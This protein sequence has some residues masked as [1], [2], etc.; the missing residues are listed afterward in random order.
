[1]TTEQQTDWREVVTERRGRD[2]YLRAVWSAY[3]REVDMIRM[4]PCATV[5]IDR[6]DNVIR[7]GKQTWLMPAVLAAVEHGTRHDVTFDVYTQVWDCD[8][9]SALPSPAAL[10]ASLMCIEYRLS[11]GLP[12]CWIRPEGAPATCG[13]IDP[14]PLESPQTHVVLEREPWDVD[15]DID[16]MTRQTRLHIYGRFGALSIRRGE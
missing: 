2:D 16:F 4:P 14:L 13:C 11:R 10:A 8:A 15:F 5:T 7:V 12:S 1:M 6:V 3:S 9:A